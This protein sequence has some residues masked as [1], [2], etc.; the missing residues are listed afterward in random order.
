MSWNREDNSPSPGIVSYQW[1][2]WVVHDYEE[3]APM[4]GLISGGAYDLFHDGTFVKT[5][6]TLESVQEFA[7]WRDG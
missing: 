6:H 4:Q 1:E 3:N 5:F 7:G 2:S